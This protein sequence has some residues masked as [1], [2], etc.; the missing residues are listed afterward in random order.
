M[1]ISYFFRPWNIYCKSLPSRQQLTRIKL[2]AM[3]VNELGYAVV[4]L[5]REKKVKGYHSL[6]KAQTF[7]RLMRLSFSRAVSKTDTRKCWT[8]NLFKAVADKLTDL[9]FVWTSEPVRQRWRGERETLKQPYLW[10]PAG[11]RRQCYLAGWLHFAI[12]YSFDS[13]PHSTTD[14]SFKCINAHGRQIREQRIR[15]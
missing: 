11:R 8:G 13:S 4:R 3:T 5:S 9:E 1:E 2:D 14:V 15:G 7:G 6:A 12:D 10:E